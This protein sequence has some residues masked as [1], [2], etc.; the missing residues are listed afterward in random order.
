MHAALKPDMPALARLPQ[1]APEW[2]T[3]RRVFDYGVFLGVVDL[4]DVHMPVLECG[5]WTCPAMR[6]PGMCSSWAEEG[7]VHLVLANPRPIPLRDQFTYRGALGLWTPPADIADR[8][9][10]LVDA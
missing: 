8:I 3:A 9:R 10:K 4:V 6:T 5:R 2:V 1:R 7:T